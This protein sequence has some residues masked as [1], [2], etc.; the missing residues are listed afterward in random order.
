MR[1]P[2]SGGSHAETKGRACQVEKNGSGK[3]QIIQWV[4][5]W[6]HGHR[7]GGQSNRKLLESDIIYFM[8]S[9]VILVAC[10]KIIRVQEEKGDQFEYFCS[11]PGTLGVGIS[12]SGPSKTIS[13]LLM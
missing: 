2:L 9:K 8:F 11:Y 1:T 3:K 5:A 4:R 12:H 6:E 7:T 13:T 10:G